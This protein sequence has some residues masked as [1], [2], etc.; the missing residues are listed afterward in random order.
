MNRGELVRL[1][2]YDDQGVVVLGTATPDQGRHVFDNGELAV[3]LGVWQQATDRS[4]AKFQVLVQNVVGWI[5]ESECEVVNA[6][7]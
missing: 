1:L 6:E 2:S 3:Y 4:D 7:G 5:Y